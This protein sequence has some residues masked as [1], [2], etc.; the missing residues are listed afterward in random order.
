MI[1][2]INH[3]IQNCGVYQYGKRLAKILLQSTKYNFVY[4]EIDSVE[5]YQAICEKSPEVIIYNYHPA[6]LPWLTDLT[7]QKRVPNVGIFHESSINVKFDYIIDID[8]SAINTKTLVSIPRPLISRTIPKLSLPEIVTIGSFGF[9]FHNKGWDKIVKLVNEQ[10]DRAIIKFNIPFA[11]FAGGDALMMANQIKNLCM[12]NNVKPGIELIITHKF[13]DDEELLLFLA[14]NTINIFMYDSM[15]GRGCSSVIDYALSVD[16]PIGIS[17]SDMFRHIYSDEICL[18][19]R[20]IA[21]IIENGNKYLDRFRLMWSDDHLIH[22]IEDFLF[23]NMLNYHRS[24]DKLSVFKMKNNTVLNDNARK[25]LLP[26]IDE[27]TLLVP[28]MMAR[29]IARANVQQAFVFKYL[30][31]NFGSDTPMICAGSYEDTCCASLRQLNYNIVEV[32][33]AINYDLHT[34]CTMTSYSQVPVVFSV[35]VI[36][37]VQDD[38][39]FVDDM[40]KLLKPGGTCILTC[41]FNNDYTVGSHKP[42]CDFRLYTKDDLLVRFKAILDRNNCFIDGDIDYDEAPDFVYESTLYTFGTLVFKKRM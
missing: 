42:G 38:E 23:K 7:M 31:D 20:S 24:K 29:K 2:F 14:S 12:I 25:E 37:H 30:K 8:P 17:D 33:P 26:I 6:T 5:Q 3:T 16:R 35:S 36:E 4:Y 39:L 32:D 40:C 27:M 13:M 18:Y 28:T 11:H 15:P 34:Y 10:Y 19:K 1:I 21:D 9:G 41:D 22:I